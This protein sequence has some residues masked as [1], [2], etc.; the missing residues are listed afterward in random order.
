[1]MSRSVPF[2]SILASLT[3]TAGASAAVHVVTPTFPKQVEPAAP[4]I[5]PA[6]SGNDELL[7]QY[8]IEPCSE[9]ARTVRKWMHRIRTDPAIAANLP[10]GADSVG[11]VSLDP[12]KRQILMRTV[13]H[14]WMR[15]IACNAAT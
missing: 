9:K 14:V 11:D 13:L 1:M 8:G 2:L 7:D 6:Q 12:E 5:A 4:L 15:L 3:V 10:E